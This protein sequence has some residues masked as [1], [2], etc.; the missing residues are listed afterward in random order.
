MAR[1]SDHTREELTEL[2]IDAA[3]ALIEA[4]GFAQFSARQVAA[5]IGYTVGTLYNVFGSY[6]SLL[7]HVQSQA[8]FA[9]TCFPSSSESEPNW[10]TNFLKAEFSSCSRFRSFACSSVSG[11]GVATSTRGDETTPAEEGA[12]GESNAPAEATA[13]PPASRTST[14]TTATSPDLKRL[15]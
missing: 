10:R 7:L 11:A 3:L 8:L 2:A 4:D 1:R 13:I 6:D 9:R 12:G 5:K 15:E 14:P